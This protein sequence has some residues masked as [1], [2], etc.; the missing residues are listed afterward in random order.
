M[1]VQN[2]ELECV[3]LA[4]KDVAVMLHVSSCNLFA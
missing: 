1:D 2:A 3:E 4:K